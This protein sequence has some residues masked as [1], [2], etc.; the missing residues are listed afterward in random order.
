MVQASAGEE[1]DEARVGDGAVVAADKKPIS[2]SE[3]LPAQVELGNVVVDG[4]TAVIEETLQRD[5]LVA[6][7]CDGG[8]DRRL[9]ENGL[10][11]CVAPLEEF[12]NNG[13]R[14]GA[15]H[16]FFLLS[17]RIRDGPLEPEQRTDVREGD[18]G[19]LWS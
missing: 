19:S 17:R 2:S 14:L 11:L 18:L 16:L 8:G 15:A 5:T 4:Q 6:R 3:D 10:D 12:F 1:G 13:A 9:V 7:V